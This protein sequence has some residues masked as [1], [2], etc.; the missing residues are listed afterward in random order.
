MFTFFV[1][2]CDEG[3][4]KASWVTLVLTSIF[5]FSLMFFTFIR[6]NVNRT[7]NLCLPACFSMEFDT[8]GPRDLGKGFGVEIYK[9]GA[10]MTIVR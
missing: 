4:F 2:E 6:K 5:N 8:G 10:E 9:V 7:S 1:P 3:S